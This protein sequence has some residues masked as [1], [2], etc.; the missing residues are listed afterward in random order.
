MKKLILTIFALAVMQITMNF[1]VQAQHGYTLEELVYKYA[2]QIRHYSQENYDMSSVDWYLA[3]SQVYNN[4]GHVIATSIN[5]NNILNPMYN[6]ESYNIGKKTQGIKYGNKNSAKAYV[7]IQK[8]YYQEKPYFKDD[9][10]I[11]YWY[12]YPWNGDQGGEAAL[13]AAWLAVTGPVGLVSIP[14]WEPIS[15]AHEGDWEYVKVI[16]KADGDLRGIWAS[17]HGSGEWYTPNEVDYVPNT[18][19]AILYSAN[20]SHALYNQ[21]GYHR[22]KVADPT[23]N[24][25]WWLNSWETGRLEIVEIG[26]LYLGYNSGFVP[27]TGKNNI[28]N[29]TNSGIN[30]TNPNWV[31][32]VGRFGK[33]NNGIIGPKKDWRHWNGKI[34]GYPH[35]YSKE[36]NLPSSLIVGSGSVCSSGYTTFSADIPGNSE[37]LDW[38]VFPKRYMTKINS[39]NSMQLKSGYKGTIKITAKIRTN[40]GNYSIDDIVSRELWAGPPSDINGSMG[41]HIVGSNSVSE[42]DIEKYNHVSSTIPG[43]AGTY[44]WSIPSSR[45]ASNNWDYYSNAGPFIFAIVGSN[46]G[47][48]KIRKINDCGASE[49]TSIYAHSD[50]GGGIG[51]GAYRIA[52]ES[53]SEEKLNP[54]ALEVSETLIYPNPANSQLTVL[55][56]DVKSNQPSTI[57]LIN[58]NGQVVLNKSVTTSKTTLDISRFDNGFYMMKITNGEETTMK[59]LIIEN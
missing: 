5:D 8:S 4:N 13:T 17:S 24:G 9:I 58:I 51:D 44:D 57:Q 42:G 11:Q 2:P 35:D 1:K 12:F 25:G 14:N 55:V 10:E 27:P 23:N 56:K 50:S 53:S 59:K 37:V 30:Q 20:E 29:I 54:E 36:D 34:I 38:D 47:W 46:S 18:K 3:G 39:G 41:G 52:D 7:H 6:N 21:T 26:N 16:V 33:Y 48:V 31:N 43:Y 22:Y 15:T 32:F 45:F 40:Y 28:I 49:Y 19:H